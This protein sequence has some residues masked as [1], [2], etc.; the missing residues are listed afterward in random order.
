MLFVKTATREFDYP[1]GDAGNV[2]GT[3]G[4]KGGVSVGSAFRRLL[5]AVRFGSASTLFRRTSPPTAGC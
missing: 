1:R 5:F 3:C 4:G 2:F